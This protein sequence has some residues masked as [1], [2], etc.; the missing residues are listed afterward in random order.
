MYEENAKLTP[1]GRSISDKSYLLTKP[2]FVVRAPPKA[3][4]RTPL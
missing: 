2:S 4:M 3:F 1:E